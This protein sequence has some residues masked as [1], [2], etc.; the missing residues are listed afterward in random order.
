MNPSNHIWRG[1][2]LALENRATVD[3]AIVI[4]R[5]CTCMDQRE[6][7]HAQK[8]QQKERHAGGG[9]GGREREEVEPERKGTIAG[10]AIVGLW[11]H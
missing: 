2:G 9:G 3:T 8:E 10:G 6:S 11:C 5:E 4:R 1:R 7:V